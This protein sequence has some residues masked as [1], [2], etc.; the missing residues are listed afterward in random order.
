MLGFVD[1]ILDRT[2][3]LPTDELVISKGLL[4]ELRCWLGT[5]IKKETEQ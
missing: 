3:V 5:V 2:R 1:E 4:K